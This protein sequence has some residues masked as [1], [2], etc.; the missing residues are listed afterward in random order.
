MMKVIHL[1]VHAIKD[2]TDR[3]YRKI[4][5]TATEQ[6]HNQPQLILYNEGGVISHYIWVVALAHGL[7]LF[8]LKESKAKNKK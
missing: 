5:L 3:E 7:D 4:P 8:L 1:C 6:L 2:L